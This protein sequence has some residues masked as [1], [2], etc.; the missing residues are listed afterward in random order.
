MKIL[1]LTDKNIK[2]EHICCGFADK[3][4]AVLAGK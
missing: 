3:K 1:T 4:I 2:D